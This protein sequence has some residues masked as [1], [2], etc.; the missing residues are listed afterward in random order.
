M[1]KLFLHIGSHKTGTTSIQNGLSE[2]KEALES[3]GFVYV[4]CGE[5][6]NFHGYIINNSPNGAYV[7]KNIDLHHLFRGN[8]NT[9]ISSEN[10]SFFFD[11]KSIKEIRKDLIPY[12]D[13]IKIIVY[14]RRQDLHLI[15]HYQEG[16]KPY[17]ESEYRLWGNAIV[18]IPEYT[19]IHRKYLD[20]HARI[21]LWS[22]VFGK[23]NVIIRIFE[24]DNLVQNDSFLDFI[25]TLNLNYKKYNKPIR[26]NESVGYGKSKYGHALNFLNYSSE[27][28]KGFVY[29]SLYDGGKYLPTKEGASLYYDNYVES[30]GLLCREY[31][32]EPFSNDEVQPLNES[33]I[34]KLEEKVNIS[35]LELLSGFSFLDADNL[36]DLAIMAEN[37]N[38]ELSY[39]LM[40][41]ARK[42]RPTGPLINKKLEQY[43]KERKKK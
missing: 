3:D 4:T 20:Y 25:S 23:D 33:E 27:Q 41:L 24:A 7:N 13:D 31:N 39:N 36:R 17:R 10:F 16:S 35:L 15:S 21:K 42:M 1:S 14:L 29:N 2:N 38:L 6:N 34:L 18:P 19:L 32:L 8:K 26:V 22:N 11:E 28:F 5:H 37:D 43:E 12:F 30:N 40:S 9:I